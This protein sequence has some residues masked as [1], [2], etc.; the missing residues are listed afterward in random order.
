MA[1]WLY[2]F[3]RKIRRDSDSYKKASHDAVTS[4]SETYNEVIRLDAISVRE[5]IY[6]TVSMHIRQ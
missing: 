5:V 2:I 4:L 3:G 1:R 6:D